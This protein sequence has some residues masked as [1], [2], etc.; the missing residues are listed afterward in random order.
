M[1]PAHLAL[2]RRE[3]PPSL[4]FRTPNPGI[5]FTES[6]FYVNAALAP[7]E[8]DGT[9]RRAGV[10]SFG[11]GGTNAHVVLEEAPEPEP[12]GPSRPW[13]LLLLSAATRTA[14]ETATDRLAAH[15]ETHPEQSLPDV[16]WTLQAGRG[17]RSSCP[18]RSSSTT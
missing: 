6:P 11:L 16:A 12:S 14:L 4:H 18:S 3:I 13:Q 7:W 1:A 15:L 10:S 8:T 5:D 17:P 2:E 9:P